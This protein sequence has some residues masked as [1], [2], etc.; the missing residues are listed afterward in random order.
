MKLVAGHIPSTDADELY[1]GFLEGQRYLHSLGVSAWQD[2]IV[3]AFAGMDDNGPTYARAARSGDLTA[4]VVG[5]LWWS[6]SRGAEQLDDLLQR[7]AE[8]SH[9]RFA[10]TA[11]K[12]MQDGVAENGTAALLAPYLDRRGHATTNTGTSFVDPTLLKRYIAA[13]DEHGFQVHVHGLGDRGVR[14][15]L[16]AFEGTNPQRR[17]HIAHLQIVSPDDIT[18]FARLGIAANIQALWACLDEQMV[19][20]TLPFLG[21]ERARQQY[22]FGDLHRA[23]THLAAGSDWPVSTPDPLAAIHVAVNRTAYGESGRAGN[24]PFLPEQALDLATAFRAYTSGSSWVNHR[25]DAGIIAPGRAAD[26]VVLD[27]DPFDDPAEV[28]AAKIVSTW[29]D[30]VPVFEA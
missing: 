8:L 23:G 11:V 4:T 18:R 19:E 2:A 20:L 22:P 6:R 26:L 16:D 24:E 25:D 3:G 27:R 10:A 14:E 5:A 28:G 7:R 15:A 12:I 21:A 29:V 1:H 13:L 9:G 17:H 30:G